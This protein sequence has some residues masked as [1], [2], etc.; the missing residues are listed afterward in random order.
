VAAAK[1]SVLS[2][3]MSTFGITSVV[4]PDPEVF[5]TPGSGSVITFTDTYIIK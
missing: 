2:I 4:D 5:E 1:H 3:K